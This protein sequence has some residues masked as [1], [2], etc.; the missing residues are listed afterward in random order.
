VHLP[1]VAA[2]QKDWCRM[3]IGEFV[4]VF[5]R[6]HVAFLRSC[7]GT[8]RRSHTYVGQLAA[9]PLAE[10]TK[11]QVLKWFHAIGEAKGG[12]AANQALQ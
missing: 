7:L 9:I 2:I 11:M 6:N 1:A 12:H 5:E 3:T 4:V 8:T 10:L